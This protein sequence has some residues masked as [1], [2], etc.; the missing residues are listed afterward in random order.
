[1]PRWDF[2]QRD[3]G[4][5]LENRHQVD[6]RRQDQV[7]ASVSV[8]RGPSDSSPTNQPE[9][10]E[11]REKNRVPRSADRKIQRDGRGRAYSLSDR[12]IQAMADVGTFRTVD[13]QDLKRFA[14]ADDQSAMSRDLRELQAAGLMEEKTLLRAHKQPRKVLALTEKGQRIV[15]KASGLPK[16]QA[17]YHG[18][19][20][21]REI[22]HDADLYKIYQQAAEKIRNEG[23]KPLRVRLDFELKRAVQR[24]KNAVKALPQEEQKKRLEAFAS[25]H[26]LAINGTR[27]HVPDVQLEY[28]TREGELERANLELVSE[29]YRNEGIRSKAQSGFAIYAR[30]GDTTRVRRA[31][32]D[33]HTVERILSI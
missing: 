10:A 30:S 29:N 20:K 11:T 17:L 23:G 9:K 21:P 6:T 31:L 2:L 7:S 16:D 5:D 24:E 28:E 14:Y 32:Q 26:T 22:E 3:S 13:V 1:M 27:I 15:R 19:V 8:G 25:E 12:E 4:R 18:F 33:T